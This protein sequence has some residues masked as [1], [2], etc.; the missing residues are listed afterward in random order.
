M[1][2]RRGRTRS[3]GRRG[4]RDRDREDRGRVESPAAGRAAPARRR[5]RATSMPVGGLL[6]VVAPA[7][8]PD[9]EIDAFVE[10]VRA[11]IVS[12]EQEE[13]GG[14]QPRD[15]RTPAGRAPSSRW[16]RASE[17]LVL[18]HGFGGDKNWLFVRQPGRGA[19]G[20]R[21][22]PARA[23][24]LGQG[25]RRRVARRAGRRRHRGPRRARDRARAP[26]RATRWAARS[27]R[28]GARR[29][30]QRGVADAARPGGLGERDR[31]RVH[32]RVHRRRT[33]R[34][35][36]PVLGRLFA[37]PSLVTRQLVDE[38][39]RYKRLDGVDNALRS[40]QASLFARRPPAARAGRRARA[41]S[42]CRSS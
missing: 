3:T 41:A 36:K 12:G 23:R 2:R 13:A 20:L 5:R 19:H 27:S 6:G 26:R 9:A 31:R 14:P 32:R 16:A 22:R 28:P 15:R 11:A 40:L 37:D 33:R 42:T 25:R 39:L 38:V 35:L 4:R 34:E 8:V 17:V 29:A 21:A 30:R 10:E 1:A 18:L 24:R 7:E